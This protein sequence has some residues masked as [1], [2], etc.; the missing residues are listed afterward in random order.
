M[1]AVTASGDSAIASSPNPRSRSVP[2]RIAGPRHTG[3]DGATG[4]AGRGAGGA[5]RRGCLGGPATGTAASAPLAYCGMTRTTVA[6]ARRPIGASRR[7]GV[8]GRLGLSSSC[9]SLPPSSARARCQRDATGRRP[10]APRAARAQLSVSPG[11]RTSCRRR[12]PRR[13][14]RRPG[15]ARFA[16]LRRGASRR[17]PFHRVAGRRG[18]AASKIARVFTLLTDPTRCGACASHAV[19]SRPGG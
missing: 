15:V 12:R 3:L 2:R 10:A 1:S 11:T 19:A 6:A 13:P 5:A 14:R 7:L 18:G 4:G 8:P 17:H 16:R 9:S